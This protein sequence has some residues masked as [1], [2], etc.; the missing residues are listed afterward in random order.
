MSQDLSQ[1]RK[2]YF[3]KEASGDSFHFFWGVKPISVDFFIFPFIY[4][5][6][7]LPVCVWKVASGSGKSWSPFLFL[8]WAPLFLAP[9]TLAVKL[10]ATRPPVD[11]LNVRRQP[12]RKKQDGGDATLSFRRQHAISSWKNAIFFSALDCLYRRVISPPS[13]SNELVLIGKRPTENQMYPSP[14]ELHSPQGE[15]K[16][17]ALISPWRI[18]KLASTPL[19]SPSLTIR[20]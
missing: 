5:F 16:K 6:F 4:F 10:E 18:R 8:S 20:G 3:A 19:P 14:D 12:E 11:V 9:L 2:T 17:A 13:I 7:L 15:N 1:N